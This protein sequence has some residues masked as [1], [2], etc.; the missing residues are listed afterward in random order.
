MAVCRKVAISGD[1]ID[2]DD[3]ANLAE[4]KALEELSIFTRAGAGQGMKYLA[5]LTK[6]RRLI[7]Q[8]PTVTSRDI[9]HLEGPQS[10]EELSLWGSSADDACIDHLVGLAS[11][12]TLNLM[13]THVT[14]AGIR[15]FKGHPQLQE[16]KLTRE[17]DPEGRT[18]GPADGHEADQGRLL[19]QLTRGAPGSHPRRNTFTKHRRLPKCV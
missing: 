13:G 8:D 6:L 17:S 19:R 15:K 11:L 14:A 2:E 12:K 7:I 10:L 18:E 16:I 4:L 1:W 9:V 5:G 3:M